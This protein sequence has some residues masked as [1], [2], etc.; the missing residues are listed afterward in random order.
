MVGYRTAVDRRFFPSYTDVLTGQISS[1]K[2]INA[3]LNSLERRVDVQI[4]NVY[5]LFHVAVYHLVTITPAGVPALTT[6]LN[7]IGGGMAWQDAFKAAFGMSVE[8]Y[9]VNFAAYRAGL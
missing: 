9:Y 7:A 8:T 6:Y 1:A 2:Q 4:P 5:S 3:P